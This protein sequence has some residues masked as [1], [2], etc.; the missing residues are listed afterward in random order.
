MIDIAD[1]PTAAIVV[2]ADRR[3]VEANA[4]AGAL[5]GRDLVGLVLD[6]VLSAADEDP[7]WDGWHASARLRSVRGIPERAAPQT[8]GDV[9]EHPD[10][11]RPDALDE[12]ERRQRE[13]H[14]VER[15]AGA[16]EPEADQPAPVAEQRLRRM[17]RSSKRKSG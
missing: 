15:E 6:D 8:G 1:L 2:D 11:A 13:R 7:A 3:I 4:D 16:L 5:A 10:P 12:R 9:G 14:D 17:K